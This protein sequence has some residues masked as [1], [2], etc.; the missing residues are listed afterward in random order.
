ML[1]NNLSPNSITGILLDLGISSPQIDVAERGF[2][3]M[4]NGVLDMRMD[5]SKG[6]P[7]SSL[8]LKLSEEELADII[9]NYGEEK[10]SRRIA[11]AIKAYDKPILDTH[12]LAGIVASV[13]R[14]KDAQ[15]PATRTFQAL[16]IYINR[17]LDDLKK[18]LED[19]PSILAPNGKIVIIS[20]HSLE[21]RIVKQAFNRWAK[22]E[23]DANA[24][25]PRHLLALQK[26]PEPT[27]ELLG[28]F[29]P[30]DAEIKANPRA[31]SAIMRVA[32]KL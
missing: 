20:F 10:Q 18:F 28:K 24:K 5:T 9:F 6:E 7:L 2:S 26:P 14:Q 22:P 4:R 11:S 15:H 23:Q 12:T 17:E 32:R 3:F 16:R 27:F 13:V 21:D 8:I 29:K 30:T 19:L 1:D 31:R 25:I